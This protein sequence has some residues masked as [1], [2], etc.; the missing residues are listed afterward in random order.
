[1]DTLPTGFELTAV[2]W[3]ERIAATSSFRFWYINDD[4]KPSTPQLRIIHVYPSTHYGVYKSA[5]ALNSLAT[6]ST[7]AEAKHFAEIGYL[8]GAFK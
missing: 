7:L 3:A 2:K 8:T 4:T 5:R 1:V 6:F